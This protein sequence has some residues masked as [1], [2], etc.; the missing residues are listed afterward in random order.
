MEVAD[1]IQH[2]GLVLSGAALVKLG[3]IAMKAWTSR[4]Q[5]TEIAND[6]LKVDKLDKYVTRGE[7]NKAIER[8]DAEHKRIEADNAAAHKDIQDEAFR[9][10]ENIF[11][12]LTRNDREMGEIKGLL[13][14]LAEDMQLIKGKLFKTRN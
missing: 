3:S 1:I 14:G 13:K 2:G 9:I 12:R 5:R 11:S 8:N 7:F 4:N 6:P 10:R